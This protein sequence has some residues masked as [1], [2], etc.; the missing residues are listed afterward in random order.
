MSKDPDIER[1]R[2]KL[3]SSLRGASP[4]KQ[5]RQRMDT[6][7][8]EGMVDASV[9]VDSCDGLRVARGAP[10]RAPR[11]S[12]PL[13]N[14]SHANRVHAIWT[15]PEANI[16]SLLARYSPSR[17][18]RSRNIAKVARRVASHYK[19]LP[20]QPVDLWIAYDLGGIEGSIV[21]YVTRW[22]N[23]GGID[24]LRKALHFAEM[25]MDNAEELAKRRQRENET[26]GRPS[27]ESYCV[28]N[29]LATRETRIVQLVCLWQTSKVITIIADMRNEILELIHDERMRDRSAVQA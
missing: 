11:Q 27:W 8:T 15:L 1:L 25:L 17:D 22:K 10:T 9:A 14:V 20:H 12:Q 5:R 23:K 6:I 13:V 16:E 29:K 24:D 19:Y 3:R 28:D 7:K 4:A 26:P 21:K 18:I 2:A